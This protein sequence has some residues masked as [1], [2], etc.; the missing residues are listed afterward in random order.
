MNKEKILSEVGHSSQ[1]P[2]IFYQP[3]NDKFWMEDIRDVFVSYRKGPVCTRLNEEFGIDKK[4]AEPLFAK[5]Y[6][7]KV[8]DLVT[9]IGG[10]RKGVHEIGGM[11]ILVPSE[12]RRIEPVK[13][14]WQVIRDYMIGML[15]EEQFEWYLGWLQTW[16]SGYYSYQF[17]AGQV[18]ICIGETSSGKTLLK[19]IHNHIFD[20]GGQPLKYMTGGTGFNGELCGVCSLHIDDKLNDLGSNGKKKLKAECK[21]LAVAGELRFEFKNKTA[22]SASPIQRLLICCN[23]TEDSVS[24]IP[25]ID[26][27]TKNKISILYCK[28][29]SMPMPAG[30]QKEKDAFWNQIKTEMPAYLY[31][32]M[33]EHKISEKFADL[34]EERMCVRGYHNEKALNFV[35]AYSNEGKRLHAIIEVLRKDHG[36]CW[37]GSASEL[38]KILKEEAKDYKSTPTSIGRFLNQR[39]ACGSKLVKMVGHRKYWID[40]QDYDEMEDQDLDV[41]ERTNQVQEVPELKDRQF[42]LLEDE[43]EDYY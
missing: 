9:R 11:N 19:S 13:G 39:I 24:V 18:L 43:D 30:T 26:N 38:V 32:V 25:D 35:E 40:V 10:R 17:V 29:R 36:L 4:K 7:E 6:Q 31:H 28:R 41:V 15:G 14:D 23:Y 20:G 34:E 3:E 16:L 8:V 5:I 2:E 1:H 21:E 12:Q 37:E 42:D 27:S 33:E 22:F